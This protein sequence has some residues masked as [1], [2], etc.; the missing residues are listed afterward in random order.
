MSY[1]LSSIVN[2]FRDFLLIKCPIARFS[3][4]NPLP[5]SA[6]FFHITKDF[7]SLAEVKLKLPKVK[8]ALPLPCSD[9]FSRIS[10][11]IFSKVLYTSSTNSHKPDMYPHLHELNHNLIMQRV[12]LMALYIFS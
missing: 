3:F 8:V 2:C 1:S 9:I 5:C 12:Y 7:L 11:S 4:E 6:A 10:L